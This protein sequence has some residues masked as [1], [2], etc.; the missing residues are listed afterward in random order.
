MGQWIDFNVGGR[1]T[2]CLS[3]VVQGD[4][5]IHIF[6]NEMHMGRNKYIVAP[7]ATTNFIWVVVGLFIYLVVTTPFIC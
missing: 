7:P 6:N 3:H 5:D 1:G 2:V 4:Y